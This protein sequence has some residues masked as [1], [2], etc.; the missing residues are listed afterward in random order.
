MTLLCTSEEAVRSFR[1]VPMN[2]LQHK[3]TPHAGEIFALAKKEGDTEWQQFSKKDKLEPSETRQG[4]KC[5]SPAASDGLELMYTDTQ[6]QH[7]Q[8]L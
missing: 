3:N 7:T 2:T 5:S 4:E 8:Q 6:T 1:V